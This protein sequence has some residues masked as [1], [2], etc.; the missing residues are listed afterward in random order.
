MKK[1]YV[2]PEMTCI[3]MAVTMMLAGSP[4]E[5]HNEVSTSPELSRGFD[6]RDEEY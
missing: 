2:K 3:Q 1:K 4:T 6:W 5:T